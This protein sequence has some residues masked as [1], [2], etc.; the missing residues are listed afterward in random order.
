MKKISWFIA[1]YLE[2]TFASDCKEYLFAESCIL[3]NIIPHFYFCNIF[4]KIAVII[5]VVLGNTCA[6]TNISLHYKPELVSQSFSFS[7]FLKR[8]KIKIHIFVKTNNGV[9]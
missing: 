2:I 1:S 6:G 7:A 5:I 9:N 3:K 8:Q 4:F